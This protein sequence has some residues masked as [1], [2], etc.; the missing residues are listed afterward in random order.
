MRQLL[1]GRIAAWSPS[2]RCARVFSL[3][4]SRVAGRRLCEPLADAERAGGAI[5]DRDRALVSHAAAIQ[6]A[7]RQ[8]GNIG[9]LA[10][11]DA[12]DGR[13]GRPAWRHPSRCLG[14]LRHIARERSGPRFGRRRWSPSCIE[15]TYPRLPRP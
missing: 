5:D 15:Q 6:A 13:S 4:E 9:A 3:R 14:P 2:T 12:K 1:L 7:I 10:F 8:S 11:L